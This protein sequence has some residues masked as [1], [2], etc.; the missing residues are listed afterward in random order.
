MIVP[1]RDVWRILKSME[2]YDLTRMFPGNEMP[3]NLAWCMPPPEYY[4][5][6]T[7]PKWIEE[8]RR[9]VAAGE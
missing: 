9:R 8:N 1:I 4:R 5:P 2:R 7:E 6:A 3:S